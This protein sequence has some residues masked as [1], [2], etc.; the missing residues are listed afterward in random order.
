MLVN[1]TCIPFRGNFLLITGFSFAGICGCVYRGL[2]G[3]FGTCFDFRLLP[4]SYLLKYL[5]V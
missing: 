5:K 3:L 2:F 1:T 4:F